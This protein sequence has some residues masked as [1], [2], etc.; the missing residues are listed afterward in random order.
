M[1]E[2]VLGKQFTEHKRP[3]AVIF[4]MD[5]TLADVSI[6]LW[7]EHHIPVTVVPGWEGG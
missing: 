7:Q 5:G 2:G 3:T 6:R 1:S 4:D